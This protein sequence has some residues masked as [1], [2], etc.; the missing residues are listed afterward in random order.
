MV[1]LPTGKQVTTTGVD[2][3]RLADGKSVEELVEW[4]ALGILQQ[5]G[6]VPPPEQ[7]SA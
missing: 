1:I 5:L 2:L 3:F 6:V 4:D 7:P